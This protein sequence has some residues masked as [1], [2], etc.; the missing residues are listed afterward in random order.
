MRL[1]F[2]A[3]PAHRTV[4]ASRSRRMCCGGVICAGQLGSIGVPW[5]R[6][7]HLGRD[8]EGHIFRPLPG[9][10]R[11]RPSL[12]LP[13]RTDKF[14]RFFGDAFMTSTRKSLPV[15]GPACSASPRPARSPRARRCR[16]GRPSPA[17]ERS[18]A[19]ASCV[20]QRRS[21]PAS[22]FTQ[23]ASVAAGRPTG[24]GPHLGGEVVQVHRRGLTASIPRCGRRRG[25]TRGRPRRRWRTRRPPA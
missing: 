13:E 22:C 20:K 17:A 14:P 12:H 6:V 16:I 8:G 18:P 9:R 1:D 4:D 11:S 19:C 25:G 15:T 7:V 5:M 10:E 23:S 2:Q 21:V 3:D 24:E